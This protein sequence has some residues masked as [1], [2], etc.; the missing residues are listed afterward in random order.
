MLELD[1]KKMLKDGIDFYI[2]ENGVWMTEYV[3]PKYIVLG[4]YITVVK[5]IDK[6]KYNLD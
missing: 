2:S 6:S 1:T 3:D 5:K 4:D